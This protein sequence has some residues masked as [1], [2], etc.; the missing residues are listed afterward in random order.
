M[1]FATISLAAAWAAGNLDTARDTSTGENM[2]ED[3][4][5]VLT[6]ELGKR[7]H[8]RTSFICCGMDKFLPAIGISGDRSQLH[9]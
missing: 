6:L 5:Y 8:S 7:G 3:E 4:G 1:W 9:L 2:I